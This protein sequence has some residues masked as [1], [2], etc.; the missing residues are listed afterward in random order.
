[1]IKCI[2]VHVGASMA[3]LPSSCLS[4][5]LELMSRL[6]QA[7]NSM[8]REFLS[9]SHPHLQCPSPHAHTYLSMFLQPAFPREL[10][11]QILLSVRLSEQG[12]AGSQLWAQKSKTVPRAIVHYNN[13]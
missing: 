10:R 12:T 7:V 1:M 11:R 2:R 13:C 4:V 6:Q 9:L 8:V 3:H 5:K